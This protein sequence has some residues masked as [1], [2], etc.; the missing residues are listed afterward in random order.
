MPAYVETML[1]LDGAGNNK[2]MAVKDFEEVVVSGISGRLPESDNL[3][4]F[5]EHLDNC[6]DMVTESNRR[7]PPGRLTDQLV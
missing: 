6:E 4:E 3:A 1:P 7:W 2:E 5:K